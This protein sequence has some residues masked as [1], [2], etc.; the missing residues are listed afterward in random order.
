MV[1]IAS[2]SIRAAAP[3][4][5]PACLAL[6]LSYETDYVWQIDVRGD[7]SGAIA[8]S[9]RTARLP[10]AMRVSYPRSRALLNAALTWDSAFGAF[11]VAEKGGALCGYLLL[12]FEPERS[13]AWIAELGVDAASRRR[14]IG[15]ALLNAAYAQA[16][17]R[18]LRHLSIETQTKNY[19]A[20]C[21]C[22]RNGLSFC[23]YNDL[24]FANGDVALFFG[25]TVRL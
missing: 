14:K 15:T 20:I 24:Y 21:F 25:Q 9:L 13:A 17:A 16:Q 22:Q 4:D 3:D 1:S 12:R 6:D 11:L 18:G 23:G 19:P 10:R 5:L 7:E 8:I 2:L